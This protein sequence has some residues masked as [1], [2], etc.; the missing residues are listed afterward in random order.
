MPIATVT[1][2]R[3]TRRCMFFDPAASLGELE[4]KPC[5]ITD[6]SGHFAVEC[7]CLEFAERAP[8]EERIRW[9]EYGLILIVLR[10]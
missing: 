4:L 3:L 1:G 9:Q 7:A 8:P 5:P 6:K 2:V 10:Y